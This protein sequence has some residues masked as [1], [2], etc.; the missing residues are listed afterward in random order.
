MGVVWG[1]EPETQLDVA[2][3]LAMLGLTTM[4]L[5]VISADGTR[6]GHESDVIGSHSAAESRS[7]VAGTA[8]RMA[9]GSVSAG[10][11]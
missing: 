11:N 8:A 5:K 10:S 2:G 6:S 9:Y 4:C 7:V 1:I 3:K